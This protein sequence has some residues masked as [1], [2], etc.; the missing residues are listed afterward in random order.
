MY[1][2]FNLFQDGIGEWRW[3]GK[4]H[5]GEII[6]DSGEGVVN[7]GDC[8]RTLLS[9]INTIRSGKFIITIATNVREK[10]ATALVGSAV[11]SRA[12]RQLVEDGY[13]VKP[14]E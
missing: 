11:S 10:Q 1:K 5:N 13:I 3:N 2:S 14:L 8:R 9:M 6:A 7:R 12:Q 4:A